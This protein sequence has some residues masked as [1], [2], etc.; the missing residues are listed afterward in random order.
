MHRHYMGSSNAFTTSD[1]DPDKWS[2]L[3]Q[4]ER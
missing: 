1:D 4:A 2:R 3:A